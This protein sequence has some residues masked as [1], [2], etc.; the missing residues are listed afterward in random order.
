M[1]QLA[2]F[3]GNNPGLF[4]ALGVVLGLLIWTSMQSMGG[5]SLSPSDATRLINDSDAIVLDVRSDAEFE[6]GHIVGSVHVV[7]TQLESA[8]GRL[9]KYKSKP[10]IA[11]CKTGQRS[12]SVCSKLKKA[13]FE[14]VYNLRGGLAAWEGASLPLTR[15]S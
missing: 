12:M 8:M 1:E 10:I 5:A 2:E 9:Q 15:K 11:T 7:D 13:G 4:A 6:G 3:M 14:Q